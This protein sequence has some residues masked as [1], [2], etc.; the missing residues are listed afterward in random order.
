MTQIPDFTKIGL[1]APPA[2]MASPDAAARAA[3]ASQ[4]FLTPEGIS[5]KPV[6]TAADA[7]GLD[8]VDGLPGIAPYLR[9]PYPAM[10]VT[11]PWI[12][13]QIKHVAALKVSHCIQSVHT[14][15]HIHICVHIDAC[16]TA[17]ISGRTAFS[18][19]QYAL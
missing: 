19:F 10:Y 4:G 18:G 1:D 9:G 12:Q 16:I 2:K 14:C 3:L 11:Q 17:R 8:F 6:Y 7:A 5:V 15:F 13:L